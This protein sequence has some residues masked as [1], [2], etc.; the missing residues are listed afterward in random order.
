MTKYIPF[1]GDYAMLPDGRIGVVGP[2][3]LGNRRDKTVSVHFKRQPTVTIARSE[4]MAAWDC[5]V[6][7]AGLP[8]FVR[9]G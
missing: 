8:K 9:E 7:T 6:G 4:I 2:L 5:V 1:E 3:E